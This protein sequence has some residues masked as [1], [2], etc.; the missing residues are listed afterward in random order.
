MKGNKSRYKDIQFLVPWSENH[1]FSHKQFKNS[2]YWLRGQI[3]SVSDKISLEDDFPHIDYDLT[4]VA[5]IHKDYTINPFGGDRIRSFGTLIGSTAEEFTRIV[6]KD[7]RRLDKESHK[8]PEELKKRAKYAID[9]FG[10][11]LTYQDYNKYRRALSKPY[12]RDGIENNHKL[13]LLALELKFDY[14]SP[15]RDKSQYNVSNLDKRTYA[16]LSRHF[17]KAVL[18][19]MKSSWFKFFQ[20]LWDTLKDEYC[21]GEFQNNKFMEHMIVIGNIANKWISTRKLYD[22]HKERNLDV[23]L[24]K[25]TFQQLRKIYYEF[26]PLRPYRGKYRIKFNNYPQYADQQ[27]SPLKEFFFRI[28]DELIA[29]ITKYTKY[30]RCIFCRNIIE[31]NERGSKRH[32]NKEDGYIN[33]RQERDKVNKVSKKNPSLISFYK[34]FLKYKPHT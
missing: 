20:A 28:I 5:L 27:Y 22:K 17:S 7:Y 1:I 15:G 18:A 8:G 25:K 3:A 13:I 11:L 23:K 19:K 31:L 30:R 26:R 29:D 14:W 4:L 34:D 9:T 12:V 21:F 24:S 32:C 33:C 2:G 16:F 6:E 10:P